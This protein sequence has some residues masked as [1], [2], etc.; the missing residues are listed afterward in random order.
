[1]YQN[2]AEITIEPTEL[3]AGGAALARVNGFPVFATNLYPGDVAVVR[4]TEVKKGYAHAK[5]VRLLQPSPLRRSMPCPIAE[6]C[7]GCD[8]TA[9]RLDAQLVAKERI[10]RESLRRIGKI[11]SHPDITIHPSP[12]NYRLRSRL[13]SDGDAVGFYAMGSNRVVPLAKECEVVGAETARVFG[14]TPSGSEEIDSRPRVIP[15]SSTA[16]R[17]DD[18]RG[19]GHVMRSREDG[20][21]S[22]RHVHGPAPD[23]SPSARLRM[24]NNSLSEDRRASVRRR[25]P[26]GG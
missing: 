4:L 5:L 12:L 26:K 8:W 17:A 2:G 14:V 24:T 7:G 21:G 11:Y 19:E 13:H 15:S 10:L 9:L 3:V 23:P 22:L 25:C 20:E 16:P 1:L 18:D 6:E